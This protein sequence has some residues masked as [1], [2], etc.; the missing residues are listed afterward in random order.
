MLGCVRCKASGR[1]GLCTCAADLEYF[2]KE[3]GEFG[4]KDPAFY[5]FIR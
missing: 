4:L 1:N 2:G 5:S 3:V